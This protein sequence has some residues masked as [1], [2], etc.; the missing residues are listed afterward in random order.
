M[1]K[2]WW[3]ISACLMWAVNVNAADINTD[4]LNLSAEQNQKLVELKENLRAEIQPIWE[5]IES[6]KQRIIEIEKKYFEEFWN[7]LSKEQ[8]QEFA[9]LNQQ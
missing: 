6:G 8:K 1:K 9:K 7:L 5:E 3:L 4:S 2:T